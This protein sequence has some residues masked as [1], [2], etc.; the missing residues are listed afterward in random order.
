MLIRSVFCFLCLICVVCTMLL[1]ESTTQEQED[2][3]LK[4][5]KCCLCLQTLV[6]YTQHDKF[7]FLPTLPRIF[8]SKKNSSTQTEPVI[9]ITNNRK[10]TKNENKTNKKINEVIFLHGSY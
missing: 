10:K 1:P 6:C 7:C 2:Q 9:H 5:A 4:L 3:E 8:I